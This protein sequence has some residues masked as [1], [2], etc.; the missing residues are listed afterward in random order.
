MPHGRVPIE[1]IARD[2]MR[3]FAISTRLSQVG[4]IVVLG[5]LSVVSAARADGCDPGTCLCSIDFC[6]PTFC[7]IECS[8]DCCPPPPPPPPPCDKRCKCR[9]ACSAELRTCGERKHHADPWVP[10][11]SARHLVRSCKKAL[12]RA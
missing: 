8:E 5:F 1:S 7:A 4:G 9:R 2:N 10:T 12:V 6:T 11:W 3:A